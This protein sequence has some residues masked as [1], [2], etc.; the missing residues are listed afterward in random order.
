MDGIRNKI[1]LFKISVQREDPHII[2]I[3]ETKLEGSDIS[4][5]FFSTETYTIFRKDRFVP[6][7][8]GGVAVLVKKCLI[9]EGFIDIE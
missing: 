7:G 1:D 4:D 8:G 3:S 2:F 5:V 9:S 6:D